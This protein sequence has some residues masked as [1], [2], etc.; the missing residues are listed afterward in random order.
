MSSTTIPSKGDR[1]SVF[2]QQGYTLHQHRP[3]DCRGCCKC[4]ECEGHSV[5][6]PGTVDEVVYWADNSIEAM[7]ACDDGQRRILRLSAPSG[8]PC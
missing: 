8:D 2:E 3:G 1:V 6:F 5:E 4:G 7:V